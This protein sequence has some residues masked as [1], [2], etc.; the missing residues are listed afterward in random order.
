MKVTRILAL[1][2]LL[3]LS[4]CS[5]N[6]TTDKPAEAAVPAKPPLITV[7]GKAISQ[8]LFEDYAKAVAGKPASELTAEDRDQIKENLV[9]IELIAQQAEKD[10]LTKDPEVANRLEL[11]RLNLLQQAA[12]G[13]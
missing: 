8:E 5:K 4:A 10:G 9:R 7:N 2:A 3:V 12:Q 6:A 11:T 13:H 1:G